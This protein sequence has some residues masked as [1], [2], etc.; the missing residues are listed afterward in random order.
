MFM[1]ES[2]P[3]GVCDSGVGGISVLR[4]LHKMLPGEDF[5]YFGDALHAPYGTR[6][7]NEIL[8]LSRNVMDRL[9]REGIK[10]VVIACN[11]ITAA[12]AAALREEYP[13]PII[14]M[15]PALKLAYDTVGPDKK[16]LVLA[17]PATTASEKYG[18]LK[19]LY[20]KNALSVPCPG[21]MEFA[22][23]RELDTP[24]LHTYLDGIFT[25]DVKKD[26][27][28]VVLGCTHYVFLREAIARHAGNA[29][30]LDGNEGTARQLIRKLN[31]QHLLRNRVSDGNI[32]LFSSGDASSVKLMHDLLQE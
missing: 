10:A 9:A 3:I 5:V 20:G 7:E 27:A 26:L 25:M 18:R 30:V 32:Q 2:A 31:E 13:F 1:Y 14:G 21:L 11:T 23:R 12:A 28:A 24:A 19:A 17:T 4:T 29:I 6:S 15:E 22:E 16:I 8:S